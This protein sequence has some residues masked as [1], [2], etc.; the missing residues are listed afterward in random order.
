M[1]PLSAKLRSNR[2]N[3]LKF[4]AASPLIAALPGR[5]SE[6]IMSPKHALNVFDFEAAARQTLPPAHFGYL[7]TGV[8]SDRTLQANRDGFTR[9]QI[10]PRRLVDV[11]RID[12][13]MP[14]FGGSWPTPIILAPTSSH[15][16][17]HPEGEIAVAR[18]ARAKRH[19][20][21]HSINATASI[22]EVIAAQAS[23]VWF[24][25]YPSPSG[26]CRAP[27]SSRPRRPVARGSS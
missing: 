13:A 3:F 27:K 6:V 8:D 25:F 23:P 12:S 9:F 18:A 24:Q 19:L 21:V 22:E 26:A 11:S 4:L 17:F 10:R 16:A 20:L 7:A 5:P 14:L 2:R 15:R 1:K